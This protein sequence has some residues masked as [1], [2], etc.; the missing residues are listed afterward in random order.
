MIRTSARINTRTRDRREGGSLKLEM[1]EAIFNSNNYPGF[2][3][4][5]RT[6]LYSAAFGTAVAYQKH[7]L[8]YRIS[9][10]LAFRISQMSPWEFSGMLGSMIDAGIANTG[11]GE[12]FFSAMA[13]EVA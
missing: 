4:P 7:V 5:A 2:Y 10:D 1:V 6:A 11:Q 13:R 9:G 12:M 8:G 3:N